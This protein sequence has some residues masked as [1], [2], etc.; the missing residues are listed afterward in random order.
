[1]S[2]SPSVYFP[3]QSDECDW[4]SRCTLKNSPTVKARDGEKSNLEESWS[5]IGQHE[6]K[7]KCERWA[8]RKKGLHSIGA[9]E[10][11]T[12]WGS[13]MFEKYLSFIRLHERVI[14]DITSPRLSI[15]S[16][17]LTFCVKS[18]CI[19]VSGVTIHS[20]LG[21]NKVDNIFIESYL[22][23]NKL[24]VI[25]TIAYD[26]KDGLCELHVEKQI[27]DRYLQ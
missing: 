6:G 20:F 23:A 19:N 24:I 10:K 17:R 11:R 12:R 9:A 3:K 5:S 27:P 7:A 25:F 16:D 21:T 8:W 22:N 18:G 1:M 2:L 15:V 14:F 26:R 13:R 4:R